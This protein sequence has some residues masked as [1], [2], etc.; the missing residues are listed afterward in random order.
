MQ[1]AG[2]ARQCERR[3]RHSANAHR[4]Q[5]WRE[6]DRGARWSGRF[7]YADD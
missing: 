2:A 7:E 4:V 5:M 6:R 1:P 3:H